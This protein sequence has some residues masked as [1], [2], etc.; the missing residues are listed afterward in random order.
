MCPRW[1]SCYHLFACHS[2]VV[3]LAKSG[4]KS[5]AP[6]LP[7]LLTMTSYLWV[8]SVTYLKS[9]GQARSCR[10]CAEQYFQVLKAHQTSSKHDKKTTRLP[11]TQCSPLRFFPATKSSFH[12]T[13]AP[14]F[15]AFSKSTA[16]CGRNQRSPMHSRS[17]THGYRSW[18]HYTVQTLWQNVLGINR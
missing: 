7:S 16:H 5:L 9:P 2:L 3:N 1:Y 8:F 6:M 12:A 4:V 18:L 14:D 15:K 11:E 17:R 13:S 10:I